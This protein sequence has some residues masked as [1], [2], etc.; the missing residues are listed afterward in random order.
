MAIAYFH[1]Q[2]WRR[3]GH[4]GMPGQGSPR[5]A[6]QSPLRPSQKLGAEEL[7]ALKASLALYFTAGPGQASGVTCLYFVEEGRQRNAPSLEGLALEH[8]AGDT[9]IRE[10]LLGLTFRISPHAFF[11]VGSAGG[12]RHGRGR[13]GG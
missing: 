3:G 5:M 6:Q 8:V 7:A 11:Q 9:H 10:D 4:G 13:C 1:P 12:A 2:V